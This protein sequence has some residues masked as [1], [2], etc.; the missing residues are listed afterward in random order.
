MSIALTLDYVNCILLDSFMT[1]KQEL[2][3]RLV[4]ES[5]RKKGTSLLQAVKYITYLL[6]LFATTYELIVI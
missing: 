1:H 6:A 2:L 5:F 3:Y 4:V